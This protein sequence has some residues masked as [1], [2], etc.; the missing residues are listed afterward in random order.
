MER[1]PRLEWLL[2]WSCHDD[3]SYTC[4]WD[5]VH[6]SYRKHNAPVQ[7]FHGKWPFIRILGVQEPASA[8]F[9]IFNLIPHIYMLKKLVRTVPSETVTYRV[10]IGYSLVSINTW[11]WST[12]FHTRDWDITEKVSTKRL[13]ITGGNMYSNNISSA[14]KE[15]LEFM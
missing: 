1:Q 15:T 8:V 3:C 6:N 9:S 2:S 13:N 10:W 4:M 14:N 5:T 7:Q 12:I 11:L